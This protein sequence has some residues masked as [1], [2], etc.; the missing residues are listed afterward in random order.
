MYGGCAL[1]WA[2][3]VCGTLRYVVKRFL[4][5]SAHVYLTTTPCETALPVPAPRRRLLVTSTS[6]NRGQPAQPCWL[7]EAYEIGVRN[8]GGGARLHNDC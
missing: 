3:T 4:E 8:G 2:G 5:L 6:N 7:R 1:L